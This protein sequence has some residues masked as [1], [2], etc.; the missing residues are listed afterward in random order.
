MV[1][2]FRRLASYL[3]QQDRRDAIR[4]DTAWFHADA[5]SAASRERHLRIVRPSP[6]ERYVRCVPLVP[7]QAAAGG[8]GGPQNIVEDD[9]WDWVEVDT[10]RALRPGM[11]VARVVGRS[12]EPVIPD[13]SYCLFSSPVAGTRQGRIVL[14]KLGSERDPETDEGYTVKRWESEKTSS[15]D[16]TWRHVTV[17]LKPD[18]P[19][20]EPIVLTVDDEDTVT[21]A[22]EMIEVIA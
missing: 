16:G 9:E 15:D 10:N 1:R 21:V 5:A 11:F 12:M 20:F 13:G 19:E 8:F 4:G 17:R 22:A 2:H 6:A 7:L 3:G 14:A 18:N